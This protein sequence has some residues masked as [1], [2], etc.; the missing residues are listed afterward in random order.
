M[1]LATLPV[2]ALLCVRLQRREI[3]GEIPEAD[4]LQFGTERVTILA[5]D[6]A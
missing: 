4:R 5:A 3:V 6:A 1:A 2:V